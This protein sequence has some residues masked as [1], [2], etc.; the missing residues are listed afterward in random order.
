MVTV[1]TP[2]RA[3]RVSLHDRFAD[4][5]ARLLPPS[6]LL[7]VMRFGAAA[8]FFLS[9]RTKVEGWFTITDSAYELFEYEYALPLIPTKIATVA[10][11]VSEHVF[12]I[13]L[14][15]GLGTRYAALALLGMTMVIEIFVYPDA[16]PTH[17]SW[18]GLLLPL[19]AM[20]G[21]KVSLDRA[22]GIL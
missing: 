17:L 15:L 6:L 3:A 14:V 16:W 13:L 7:L 21:G 20:G 11:T 12:P 1:A 10:A 9:G 19:I 4:L 18:A 5:A 22:L 8:I 2:P